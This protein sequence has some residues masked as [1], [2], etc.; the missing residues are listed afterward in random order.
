[1]ELNSFLNLKDNLRIYYTKIGFKLKII[2]KKI[3]VLKGKDITLVFFYQPQKK[4]MKV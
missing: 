1:M 3:Y 4:Y 2:E